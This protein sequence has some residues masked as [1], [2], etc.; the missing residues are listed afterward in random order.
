MKRISILIAAALVM[1]GCNGSSTQRKS[2]KIKAQI[3]AVK[4]NANLTQ[5]E[6]EWQVSALTYEDIYLNHPNDNEGVDAFRT[7]VTN[8]WSAER[9][10]SEFAKASS[11][12]R[13]NDLIITK[14]ESLKHA[15]N[16]V[17]GK[18][19][20]EISGPN[21]LSGETLCIG[22]ILKQGK[23]VLVD[24]WASWCGPCR[25]EIREHLLD[26]A[27]QGKVNI[28]GIAVWEDSLEDTQGAMEALG[29]SWPVIYTGGRTGSP[30]I[31]YGVMGI[32]TIF[33][34]SPD[35]TILGSAH[36][37]AEIDAMAPYL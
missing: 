24:F 6:I 10:E 17:P 20:I 28:I 16:V 32:P 34:L 29:I 14:M 26:I 5:E 27:A 8:F 22:D 33:M 25:L 7:L 36:S 37:V 18:P 30:S 19:Y 12:I 3:E 35:G 21:A 31:D 11:L 9:A 23:P 13:N 15:A 4:A 1:A 2:N